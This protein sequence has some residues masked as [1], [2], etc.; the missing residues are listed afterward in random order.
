[1]PAG[2]R[3]SD[4]PRSGRPV[5]AAFLRAYRDRRDRRGGQEPFPYAAIG[6][7]TAVSRGPR[8]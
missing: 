3:F 4:H 1:M 8:R 5:I 7:G 6:V 2:A